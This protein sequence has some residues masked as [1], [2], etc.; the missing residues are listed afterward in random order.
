MANQ[1]GTLVSVAMKTQITDGDQKQVIDLST[2]GRLFRKASGL[3]LQF[4]EENQDVGP[5]N[6]IIKIGEN[7]T[8]TVIRQGAVSMKQLFIQGEKTEGVY[9]SKFATMLMT[10]QTRKCHVDIKEDEALGNVQLS[11]QLH[12][13]S[14][15]AGDYKV[16]INFRR[17]N[18]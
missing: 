12:M 11:Y 6:Q 15:F 5:V 17:K 4:L 1:E 14:E 8:V 13:Q 9:R 10:T 16:T 18:E 3:Y 7:S 2:E